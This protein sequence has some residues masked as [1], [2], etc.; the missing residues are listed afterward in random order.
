VVPRYSASV[1]SSLRKAPVH[2]GSLDWARL[3]RH[4]NA[5][6]LARDMV[7]ST[8]PMLVK[9]AKDLDRVKRR[10]RTR[11]WPTWLVAHERDGP[12]SPVPRA[13]FPEPASAV[14]ESA[15]PGQSSSKGAA[16]LGETRRVHK[17][18]ISAGEWGRWHFSTSTVA[19]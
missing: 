9:H 2:L 14:P 10:P 5:E 7:E 1:G 11:C 3:A 4:L 15:P 8:V 16:A 6:T 13:V 12:P 17:L 18:W 19:A